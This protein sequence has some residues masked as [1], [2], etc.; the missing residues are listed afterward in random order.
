MSKGAHQTIIGT[1]CQIKAGDLVYAVGPG[2]HAPQG[3]TDLRVYS[4]VVKNVRLEGSY[5][6][7]C[8]PEILASARVAIELH[9]DRPVLGFSKW[10]YSGHEV[11]INI[12]RSAADALRAFAAGAQRRR[13]AAERAREHADGECAWAVE[14]TKALEGTP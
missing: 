4:T 9:D 10:T 3:P 14:Q 7:D 8:P 5:S 1:L 6:E 2:H 13:D 11:G 12:H